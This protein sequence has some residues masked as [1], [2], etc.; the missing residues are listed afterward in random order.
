MRPQAETQIGAAHLVAMEPRRFRMK[1][2]NYLSDSS[3]SI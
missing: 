3:F 1:R 2:C